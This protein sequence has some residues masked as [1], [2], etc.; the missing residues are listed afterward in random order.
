[1]TVLFVAFS[2]V[3][4]SA[5]CGSRRKGPA[6][7]TAPAVV[8]T[9][10]PAATATATAAPPAGTAPSAWTIPGLSIPGLPTSPRQAIVGRWSV[11]GVDGKPVATAPGMATDPL[12]P[13]SYVAGTTVTFDEAR[14]SIARIGLV[15]YDQPYKV[16]SEFPPVRVTIDAGWGPSNVDFAIDGSVI[17]SLPSTPPHALSLVRAQ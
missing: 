4:A 13:A 11:A 17:W 12:D 14:V 3:A 1:V 8:A 7:P 10:T 15:V 16:L 5:A 2:F 6:G 9:V